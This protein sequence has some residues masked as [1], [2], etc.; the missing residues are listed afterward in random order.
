MSPT[1]FS[2]FVGP[3]A[4]PDRRWL[5]MVESIS[6]DGRRPSRGARSGAPRESWAAWFSVFQVPGG[7]VEAARKGEVPGGSGRQDT[8][9]EALGG[10]R[11]TPRLAQR[12]PE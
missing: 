4:L 10:G 2:R 5:W 3:T 8:D 6:I 7:A 11:P 9:A 1:K 12:G